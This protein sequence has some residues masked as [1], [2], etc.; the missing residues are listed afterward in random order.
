MTTPV[1]VNII[2]RD[3]RYD[4]TGTRNSVLGPLKTSVLDGRYHA[5]GNK[6]DNC[7][8]EVVASFWNT[9]KSS[10]LTDSSEGQLPA[11]CI[12]YTEEG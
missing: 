2:I 1:P 3:S 11:R 7:N 6:H 8:M 12:H 10:S 4:D 5:K 9:R